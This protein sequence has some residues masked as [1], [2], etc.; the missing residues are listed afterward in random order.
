MADSEDDLV[1]HLEEDLEDKGKVEEVEGGEEIDWC[2]DVL[3]IVSSFEMWLLVIAT[4]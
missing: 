1:E 3:P 2:D 4:E